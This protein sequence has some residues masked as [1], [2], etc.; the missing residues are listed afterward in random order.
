MVDKDS[1][2]KFWFKKIEDLHNAAE[3]KSPQLECATLCTARCCPQ[4]KASKP[5]GYI[6]SHV[7]IMLPFEMEYIFEKT[8]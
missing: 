2:R 3:Q 6:V 1:L 5:P 4:F 8:G 7:A